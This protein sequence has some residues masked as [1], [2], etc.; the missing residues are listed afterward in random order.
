LSGKST[1]APK[2]G[3]TPVALTRRER[4][5]ATLV[6]TFVSRGLTNRQIAKELYLSERTIENHISK[7]LRKL[8][9]ASKTE[10][11]AWATE[12]RLLAPNPD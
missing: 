10:I 8:E 6:S 12:Q 1:S 9:L 4:E 7:I 5:V 3:P 2:I 11:A